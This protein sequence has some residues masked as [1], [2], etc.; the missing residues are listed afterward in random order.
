MKIMILILFA[1]FCF[2]AVEALIQFVIEI[3]QWV[4][5]EDRDE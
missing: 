3:I 5:K 4:K 1:M 2:F